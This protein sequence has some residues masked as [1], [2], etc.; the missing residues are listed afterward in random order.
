MLL[1]NPEK[2]EV[3]VVDFFSNVSPDWFH[4]LGLMGIPLLICA[5][6]V[7]TISLERFVYYVKLNLKWTSYY[8]TIAAHVICLKD[9]PKELRDEVASQ[10]LSEIQNSFFKGISLLRTISVIS[11]LLGLL[12]TILGII[13][14]F[15]VI[16]VHT[17]PVSP[18]M[19]ADGLWEAMLT[20]AVGLIIALPAIMTAYVFKYLGDQKIHKIYLQLNRL[21]MSYEL[22]KH[23]G[24]HD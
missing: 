2:S 11:P 20:T 24:C 17:G 14:A 5:L 21:S 19:I 12:G 18:S 22:K 1:S 16:A 13:S 6:L 23:G 8:E 10:I 15:K 9:H 7:V 3:S 4:L